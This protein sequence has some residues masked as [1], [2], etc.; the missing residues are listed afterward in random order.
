DPVT[1]NYRTLRT[2]LSFSSLDNPIK[3]MLVT[4]SGPGE[5]KSLTCANLGISFAETGIRTLILDVDLRKP[6]QHKLFGIEKKIGLCNYV[7]EEAALDD[8]IHDSG[9]ENLWLIPV[10]K[11]PPN[12][13]EILASR[14]FA[15]VMKNLT[16]KF[17]MVLLDTPPVMSV[18]DPVLVSL[19]VGGVLFIIKYGK[20]DKQVAVNAMNRLKKGRSNLLGVVLNEI[21]YKRGYGYYQ[22]FDY[23]SYYYSTDDKKKK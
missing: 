7:V 9:V 10:G 21:Q 11:I 8:V 12:P 4:S 16:D 1:E 5:G 20:T 3:S 13:A 19:N 2:N 6:V 17:D 18:T 23:Y 15:E 22:Y 14:K